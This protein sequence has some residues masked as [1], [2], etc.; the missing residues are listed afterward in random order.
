L[1]SNFIWKRF[2]QK[3]VDLHIL[4]YNQ[5]NDYTWF[6][7]AFVAH[8]RSYPCGV[9]E[10]LDEAVAVAISSSNDF[11]LRFR[12][13]NALFGLGIFSK[14]PQGSSLRN[15]LDYPF[16]ECPFGQSHRC[17]Q[18]F[19]LCDVLVARLSSAKRHIRWDQLR[20]WKSRITIR[21]LRW[22]PGPNHSNT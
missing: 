10:V 3:I 20:T 5:K 12:W 17:H 8:Q 7:G 13:L 2:L 4:N 14:I 9:H 6:H 16:G 18:K 21:W 19:Y 1:D 15:T 11:L 22:S